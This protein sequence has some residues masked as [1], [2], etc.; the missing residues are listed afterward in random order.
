MLQGKPLACPH[1]FV[2][3]PLVIALLCHSC[4][5]PLNRQP[6]P[7]IPIGQASKGVIPISRAG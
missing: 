7:V 3:Q 6:A 2:C 5:R 4:G 1:C